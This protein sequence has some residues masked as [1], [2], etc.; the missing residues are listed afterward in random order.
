M[1][2]QREAE[3][4]GQVAPR[5][6]YHG[7]ARWDGCS[8]WALGLALAPLGLEVAGLTQVVV[9]QGCLECGIRGLGE[10]GEDAHGLEG[11][12]AGWY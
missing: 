10:D 9:V 7:A 11:K 4:P 2:F 1:D 6:V 12:G 3:V 8:K 5:G